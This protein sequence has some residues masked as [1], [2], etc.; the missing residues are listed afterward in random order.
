[1]FP[2]LENQVNLGTVPLSPQFV[3][4]TVFPLGSFI[5]KTVGESLA[6]GRCLIKSR[7]VS[8]YTGDGFLGLLMSWWAQVLAAASGRWDMLL[9]AISTLGSAEVHPR[10]TEI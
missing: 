6:Y 1:M 3:P 7:F 4:N 9:A 8:E 10:R 2:P 5:S